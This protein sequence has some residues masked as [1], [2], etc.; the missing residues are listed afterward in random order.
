MQAL[1]SNV[2]ESDFDLKARSMSVA[3]VNLYNIKYV[4]MKA[5]IH[6]C[7]FS[8]KCHFLAETTQTK[9]G[10]VWTKNGEIPFIRI[11]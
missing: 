4:I 2:M 9:A 3:S 8:Q 7:Y 11:T 10:S 5:I 1:N 6:Y